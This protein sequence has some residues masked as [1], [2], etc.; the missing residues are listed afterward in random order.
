MGEDVLRPGQHRLARVQ[1][2]NWGT[3][4]GYHDLPVARRG[5]LITGP[6]GSG[7]STLLDA[8]SAVLV[9]AAAQGRGR[10]VASYIRGAYARGSDTETRELR[11]RYLREGATWSAVGLTMR[12][13]GDDGDTV[14]T[15]IV[16]FHLKRGSNDVGES[17]RAFLLF[18]HDLDITEL[19][20][21]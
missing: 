19:R 17:G 14:T 12:T 21:W 10:T 2:F 15:L 6:S 5:F 11:A 7:K 1:L 9:N 18:E 13:A 20:H 8:I 4:D 16:L 3:Y